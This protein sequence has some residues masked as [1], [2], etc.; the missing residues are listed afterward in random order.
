MSD[1][2]KLRKT[3]KE[4]NL[5]R[6]KLYDLYNFNKEAK[7]KQAKYKEDVNFD[8][9]IYKRN[10]EENFK[11]INNNKSIIKSLETSLIYKKHKVKEYQRRL[12]YIY[13][14]DCESSGISTL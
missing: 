7:L 4:I 5:L 14:V 13:A 12:M 3:L 11:I 9:E 1:G 6:N 10:K 2:Q 8:I